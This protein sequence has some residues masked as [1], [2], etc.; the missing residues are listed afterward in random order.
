MIRL[1]VTGCAIGAVSIA[2]ASA[3][4]AQKQPARAYAPIDEAKYQCQRTVSRNTR[5]VQSDL[6]HTARFKACMERFG[7][8]RY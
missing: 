4:T 6:Q 7:Y 1:I 2:L 3:A 8:P 5:G